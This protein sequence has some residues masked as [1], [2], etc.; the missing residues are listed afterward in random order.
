M[1]ML[2]EVNSGFSVLMSV[3][4]KEKPQ[5]LIQCLDSLLQ[6][7][8]PADEWVIVEDGPLT[9]ALYDVLDLYERQHPKLI[10]RIRLDH[11]AGLGVALAEGIRHC[12]HELIARMDADDVSCAE[13]FEE[14]IE[15]FLNDP[16]LDIC[17]TWIE[18]SEG[19]IEN[20]VSRRKVPVEE[21]AIRTYQKR[22][23]AFNHMTVMY[24]KRAVLD[25][26]NY[27]PVPLMEDTVLWVRMLQNNAH[28]ANI[29]K[30]LV[31]VR[32]GNDYYERRGGWTYF[33][34]Y[35]DG[36]REVLKTGFISRWDY[37]SSVLA[38]FFV[39]LTP[40]AVR[41]FVFKHLLHKS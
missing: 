34:L 10:K 12:S 20:V 29:P 28:C 38:Q 37:F 23:D 1:V 22:R 25:A 4:K 11:H 39:A 2:H 16:E 26:G 40:V 24:K 33:K 18:E 9:E 30:Y 35:R 8:L 14:Q 36:R 6:Q 27:E 31:K 5:Y 21:Q 15:R 13:R 32:V 19:D 7:T 3:Y 17:G 41:G